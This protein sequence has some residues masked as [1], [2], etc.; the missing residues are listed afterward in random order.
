MAQMRLT[1]RFGNQEGPRTPAYDERRIYLSWGWKCR[2]R[3]PA[4]QWQ[5]STVG[6]AEHAETSEEESREL[7]KTARTR[8]VSV[9]L[10]GATSNLHASFKA[11]ASDR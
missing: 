8:S 10:L 2:P 5:A 4:G 7:C 9:R 1:V 3:L 6:Q 11:A